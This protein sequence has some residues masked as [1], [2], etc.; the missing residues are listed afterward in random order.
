M[1][2]KQT[3]NNFKDKTDKYIDHL[4][5]EKDTIKRCAA[6]SDMFELINNFERQLINIAE[7]T[8]SRN[9][10]MNHDIQQARIER[11]IIQT[12]KPYALLMYMMIIF[13]NPCSEPIDELD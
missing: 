2:I 7:K 5:L 12:L 13:N 4:N 11:T 3:W 1:D 6:H 10:E 8:D 9:E